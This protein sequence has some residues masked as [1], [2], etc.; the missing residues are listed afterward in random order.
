MKELLEQHF[1]K[2]YLSTK[3]AIAECEIKHG[4]FSFADAKAC[5]DCKM[6]TPELEAI[7]D[8]VVVNFDSKDKS[9]ECIQLERFID[10]YANLKAFPSRQKCDLMLVDENKVVLCEMTCSKSKYIDSVVT[11]ETG[12]R[13]TAR[14]QIEG[15]ISL[16][17]SV[18]ELASEIAKR[19]QK[20]AL[21]AY[22]TKD[23]IEE[24][25]TFDNQVRSSIRSFIANTDRH[26]DG[27][28]YAD[29]DDG[30]KFAEIKY[31]DLYIW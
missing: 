20:I 16:L 25:D 9:V 30:F 5:D 10:N 21:F 7:C 8:K 27:G 17:M 18:P 19:A 3:Q 28:M 31:P 22:R 4:L 23:T 26:V 12:K 1:G 14:K 11:F 2:H 15:A 29:M 13:N 24:I 6:H